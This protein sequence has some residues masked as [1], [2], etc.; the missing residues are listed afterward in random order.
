MHG[1]IYR[2]VREVNAQLNRADTA[3]GLLAWLREAV[4]PGDAP[5]EGSI[6][7]PVED[8]DLRRRELQRVLLARFPAAAQSILGP[9]NA[10][11]GVLKVHELIQHDFL[12]EN[13]FWDLFDLLLVT[14]FPEMGQPGEAG[15]EAGGA[16]AS[17]A[18]APAPAADH[19]AHSAE[20]TASGAAPPKSPP[21][22]GSAQAQA[23]GEG[24]A[25]RDGGEAAGKAH[26][27]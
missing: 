2:S 27:Q 14:L 4:W 16:A 26:A 15:P 18:Q 12:L 25:G 6:D 22:R 10:R 13:L 21:R 7:P 19:G 20:A 1:S 11:L 17:T 24:A 23:K 3:A 9:A 5:L 8:Q